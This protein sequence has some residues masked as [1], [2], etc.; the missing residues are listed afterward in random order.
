MNI[1]PPV[2]GVTNGPEWAQDIN[3]IL[4]NVIAEHN[5]Q[6]AQDGGVQLTQDAL[7]I[8]DDLSLNG[9]QLINVNAIGLATETSASVSGSNR[10]YNEAGDLYYRDGNGAGV[11]ITQNGGL[12]AASFGGIS[13]L[14]GTNGSATFA[15]L[16]TFV[17]KKQATEYATMENGPI[18]IYSGNDPAPTNGIILQSKDGLAS[19]T[20][21]TL[22]NQLPA[23]KAFM[24]LSGSGE[25]SASVSLNKGITAG[26]LQDQIPSSKIE[27]L[28]SS[29]SV[30]IN[31][32]PVGSFSNIAQTPVL[33]ANGRPWLITIQG[34][35]NS[36]YATPQ[37]YF[38]VARQNGAANGLRLYTQYS[39]SNGTYAVL[40]TLTLALTAST[41]VYGMPFSYFGIV[42]SVPSGNVQFTLYGQSES[43]DISFSHA[44][45]CCVQL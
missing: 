22:P 12:A 10:L 45:Y 19:N 6:P 1:T 9:N 16:S 44:N 36:I 32:L 35:P 7:N 8:T 11:R 42:T 39:G 23:D 15:G 41:S 40:G 34:Y 26:M 17:W 20:T 13:G 33:A 25:I 24:V 14:S 38:N 21:L 27:C 37:G 43:G 28:V 18:K 30:S 4:T 5:H 29:A 3:N 2:V 31:N